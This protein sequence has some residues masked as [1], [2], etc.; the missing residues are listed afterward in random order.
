M[1]IKKLEILKYGP[2]ESVKFELN[3]G[4]NTIYGPNGSGK[5]LIIEAFQKLLIGKS[6][7]RRL[8]N[9]AVDDYPIGNVVLS[10]EAGDLIFDGKQS[11]ENVTSI[12]CKD[13]DQIFLVK[14]GNVNISE[15]KE[16]YHDIIPRLI[17]LKL[18]DIGIVKKNLLQ[19]GRMASPGN[20]LNRKEYNKPK[21]Q[22]KNAKS[23]VMKI[24][25]WLEDER[26]KEYI[27]YKYE[28]SNLKSQRK[29]IKY[30]LKQLEEVKKV[31]EIKNLE[32]H[33]TRVND[34]KNKLHKLEK[35]G[36][37]IL[38]EKID[39]YTTE[40]EIMNDYQDELSTWKKY[41]IL[42]VFLVSLPIIAILI[43]PQLILLSFIS[44]VGLFGIAWCIK[45]TINTHRKIG[46]QVVLEKEIMYSARKLKLLS[47]SLPDLIEYIEE[48]NSKISSLNREIQQSLGVLINSEL[49]KQITEDKFN[50]DQFKTS[51]NEARNK[52]DMTITIEYDEQI[53]NNLKETLSEVE[54]GIEEQRMLQDDYSNSLQQLIAKCNQPTFDFENILGKNF[55][56]ELSNIESLEKFTEWL[57]DLIKTIE[58]DMEVNMLAYQIFEKIFEKETEKIAEYFNKNTKISEITS[59]ITNGFFKNVTYDPNEGSFLLERE[60]NITQ[61]LDQLSQGE[62][63]QLYF[64]IRLA[65]GSKCLK[66][67]FMIMEDPFLASDDERL[68][69]QLKILN[70][71]IASGWQVLIFTAKNN[72]KEKVLEN[73]GTLVQ[74][75][76]RIVY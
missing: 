3:T 11:I 2:V 33:F 75:L 12:L 19:Q 54:S 23:V 46:K 13:L 73:G 47:E 71:F 26:S 49:S 76:D 59:E 16:F 63:G 57:K 43:S 17:G 22:L 39:K 58:N 62:L 14:D 72:V 7:A 40:I 27:G 48:H 21:S 60:S 52:L 1:E 66:K 74:E 30:A 32:E 36:L 55:E 61:N 8:Q 25:S 28:I 64:A 29:A 31:K 53:Y 70:N 4:L 18:E 6:K 68:E 9:N 69:E 15:G 24:A 35:K 45:G 67:G 50:H 10:N 44:I 65:L 34:S 38:E 41:S 51:L 5:T 56:W 20:L 42:Y 37:S